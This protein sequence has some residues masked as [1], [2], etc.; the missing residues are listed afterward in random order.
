VVFNRED[1]EQIYSK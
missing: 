1:A